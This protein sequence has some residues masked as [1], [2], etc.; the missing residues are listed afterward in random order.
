MLDLLWKGR[1]YLTAFPAF[2]KVPPKLDLAPI[3]MDKGDRAALSCCTTD[4]PC[5]PPSFTSL[6]FPLSLPVLYD[7]GLYRR[8]ATEV[9]T[10]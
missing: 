9:P 6:K 7:P 5:I 8:H 4:Y 10:K 2:L 1:G 3:K